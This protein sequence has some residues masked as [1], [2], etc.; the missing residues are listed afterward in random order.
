M[1]EGQGS[2]IARGLRPAWALTRREI[3]GF[4]RR[5][6]R[7]IGGL[8]TP[9]VFWLLL[10]GGFGQSFRSVGGGGEGYQHYFFPGSLVLILL[11][12]AIFSTISLIQDRNEGF[13]QGI[14]VTPAHRIAL[15]AGKVLGCAL[16]AVGHGLIFLALAPLAGIPLSGSAVLSLIVAMLAMS[17]ELSAIGLLFAWR[18]DSVQG[19]HSI[20]NL[21]LM[22]MWILSGAV[23]PASG[24][25]GWLKWVTVLNPLTYGVAWVRRLLTGDACGPEV[26]G[27]VPAAGVTLLCAAAALFGGYVIA[28]RR[29]R[30]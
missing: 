6:A 22:P 28:S 14:L 23:F 17:I 15:V 30:P 27:I 10:G 19:F 1:V 2:L 13:L 3:L 5:P 7:I 4:I 9:I 8:G 20:M 25:A 18:M 12:T 26:P 24:A 21:I 11:F 16:L 29:E